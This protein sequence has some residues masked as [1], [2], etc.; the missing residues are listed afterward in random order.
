MKKSDELRQ[1]RSEV[2]DQMT[3]LHRSAG[4]DT[5]TE[6]M[7]T[8]WND[9]NK[10]AEDLNAAIE[11]EALIEQEELRR[12]N[13]AAKAN[14][15]VDV[16]RV[17]TK[18]SEDEKV[19]K[20]FRL[21]GKDGAINQLLTRGRLEGLAAEVHQEGTKEAREAGL[22]STGNI[23]IPK[24]FV[25][26]VGRK[27][28]RDLVVGTTTLGGFTVATEVGDL[29][30][31]LNPRLV[32]EALGAT[33]LTGLSSNIDFP[34]N[35]SASAAAWEG[36]NTANDETSPTFDRIQLSPNRLGA[37]TDIS[38]Q[39]LVQSTVDIENFVRNSLSV[40]LANALD[41]AAINGSGQSNQPLGILNTAGI[42]S[43]SLGT[44]GGSPNFK[45]I[46]DLETEIAAAN[47][48]FGTMAYLT[49]PGVRGFL[50]TAEKATNTAQFVY[51]DSTVP[52]EGMLNGYR[53]RVSTLVPSNLTKGNGSNLHSIIFG[54]FSALIIGQWAGIDLVVDPYTSAKNA[55]VTLVVNSWWDVA[56]RH[57]ASFAAIKDA[58]VTAGI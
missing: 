50:K 32:T 41:T 20:E 55:L 7:Q 35:D 34:R 47:A 45:A 1:K 28:N 44:D 42:G 2:L 8:K 30:P 56:V 38:K 21:V 5:F 52:G 4:A 46:V 39:L 49:T 15:N 10:R 19:A 58:D 51:M 16:R 14:A 54:D 36:E 12:A 53:T 48:D 6:E 11:R 57:A 40:A 18:E 27:E 43:V 3:A 33:Y 25:R 26:G 31:F 29:I 37:F 17:V 24:M 9:L 22:N 23:T 13:D